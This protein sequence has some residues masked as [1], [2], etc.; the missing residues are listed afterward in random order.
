MLHS[1]SIE[2]LRLLRAW[3]PI[4]LIAWRYYS[5][6]LSNWVSRFAL[7]IDKAL[8]F[9]QKMLRFLINN[10]F[11]YFDISILL[12]GRLSFSYFFFKHLL[13]IQSIGDYR[14]FFKWVGEYSRR[15]YIW[16]LRYW[17]FISFLI[18]AKKSCK[19][20][21]FFFFRVDS[22]QI[23]IISLRCWSLIRDSTCKYSNF[24]SQW[25]CR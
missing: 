5:F 20:I 12:Y 23:V 9:L 1:R 14:C 17:L 24:A 2:S 22:S 10:S 19:K 13:E 15:S 3:L 4:F 8:A 6:I 21:F 7:F 11:F 16:L 18:L 25:P